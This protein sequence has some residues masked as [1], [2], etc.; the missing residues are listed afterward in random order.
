[1]S[2]HTLRRIAGVLERHF[3]GR[4]DMTDWGERPADDARKAA[5][6]RSVAAL[7]V[8]SLAGVDADTAAASV[9]DGFNDNGIDAIFFDQKKDMLLL[10]Q[11]KWSDD[12]TKPFDAEASNAF[13]AGARDLLAGKFDRFN[14]KIKSRSAEITAVLYA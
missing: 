10:I 14:E 2:Q 5:L 13:V 12:G 1:M 3:G 9:T 8:K 7:C 6:S 11:S 4:I